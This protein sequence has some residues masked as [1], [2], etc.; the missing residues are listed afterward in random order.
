MR[1]S[2]LLILEIIWIVTGILSVVAA[3]RFAMT[4][5]GSKI[6]I[7]A[8]MALISFLFAWMRHRQR[9]KS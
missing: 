8:L 2:S 4:T 9:K 1:N 5:G 3:I 7:F 6:I